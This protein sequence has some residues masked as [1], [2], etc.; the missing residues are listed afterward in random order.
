MRHSKLT[1]C[2]HEGE[3]P[4]QIA[5]AA[6]DAAAAVLR[7]FLIDPKTAQWCADY[8]NAAEAPQMFPIAVGSAGSATGLDSHEFG[9]QA[10]HIACEAA[11]EVVDV[12]GFGPGELT[13]YPDDAG[14]ARAGWAARR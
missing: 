3:L 14:K 1:Y 5:A 13:N 9:A 11:D 12:F 6:V 7:S 2:L 8:L 4:A 10:W